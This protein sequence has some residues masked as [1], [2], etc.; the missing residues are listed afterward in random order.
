MVEQKPSKLT[1]R[2]RFPSPAPFSPSA[3]NPRVLCCAAPRGLRWGSIP[4]TRSIQPQ[5]HEPSSPLL[6]CA[7]R[8][9]LGF[10]SLH[11]L[12]RFPGV[13]LPSRRFAWGLLRV[14][15]LPC[16][17][18]AA[19]GLPIARRECLLSTQTRHSRTADRRPSRSSAAATAM[20][21]GGQSRKLRESCPSD[22]RPSPSSSYRFL[23]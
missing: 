2:V 19:V 20:R 12:Q 16:I 14:R 13:M 7:Q 11:P 8:A 23:S 3:T 10:D 1:T 22:V 17:G 21:E 15:Y 18:S 5:R 4:F 6:R 9:S